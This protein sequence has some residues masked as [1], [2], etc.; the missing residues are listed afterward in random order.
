MSAEDVGLEN[1]GSDALLA[2]IDHLRSRRT[3][4]DNLPVVALFNGI[5]DDDAHVGL[6]RVDKSYP[7]R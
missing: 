5:A 1:L 4:G 7:D 2:G 6:D 3:G